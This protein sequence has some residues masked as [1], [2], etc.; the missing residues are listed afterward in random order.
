MLNHDEELTFVKIQQLLVVVEEFGLAC[1]DL[2][3]LCSDFL[4]EPLM[5]WLQVELEDR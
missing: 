3:Q 5:A 1:E 4:E 2:A